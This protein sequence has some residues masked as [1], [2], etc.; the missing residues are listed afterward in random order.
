MRACTRSVSH[1]II[2]LYPIAER[3]TFACSNLIQGVSRPFTFARVKDARISTYH[4]RLVANGLTENT[5]RRFPDLKNHIAD[6]FS[7]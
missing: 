2:L 1:Y 3:A 5:R 4:R 6:S 7:K